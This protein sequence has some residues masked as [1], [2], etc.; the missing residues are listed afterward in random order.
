MPKII[1]IPDFMQVE[2]EDK[3]YTFFGTVR[4]LI[5]SRILIFIFKISNGKIFCFLINQ[6]YKSD[7]KIQFKDGYYF[8]EF[9]NKPFFFPNKRVTRIAIDSKKHLEKLFDS[10]CLNKIEFKENDLVVDCGANVGE[11]Y[12]AF[13]SLGKKIV[14]HAFEPDDSSF[15]CLSK[16]INNQENI[17]KFALS[18]IE[19]KELIYIDTEGGNTSLSEF[20]SKNTSIVETKKLDSF[21]FKNIKLLKIDAEGYEPEVLLGC[22]NSLKEIAYIAV[23]YGN[24]RGYEGKSTMVS[25]TNFLY[26][27]SFELIEDSLIRKIGL[28]ANRKKY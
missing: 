10:Y 18:N 24:E 17:H 25:V 26:K 7:G 23:D 15:V 4:L 19:G 11:L 1:N 3:N 5:K 6:I 16:N 12:L 9:G 27:N 28:F 14:Y 8:K 20:N 22:K 2:I 21:N 13:E